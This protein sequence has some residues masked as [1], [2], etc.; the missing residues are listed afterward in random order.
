MARYPTYDIS[1]IP[2]LEAAWQK[3]PS[4]SV[5]RK[6]HREAGD[7]RSKKEMPVSKNQQC[8]NDLRLEEQD[9]QG[10]N[11]DMGPSVTS[12]LLFH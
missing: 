6:L 2:H 9:L 11:I 10:P 8:Q 7:C 3:K 1:D 5:Q 4:P 12:S